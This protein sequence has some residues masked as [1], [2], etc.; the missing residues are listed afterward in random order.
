MY[1]VWVQERCYFGSEFQAGNIFLM[2]VDF[3]QVSHFF[4][5]DSALTKEGT[6]ISLQ[7]S[8]SLANSFHKTVS[9]QDSK[10]KSQQARREFVTL[11]DKK[12][13]AE[14]MQIKYQRRPPPQKRFYGYSPGFQNG[15]R[16]PEPK[17]W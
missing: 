4:H 8:T 6:K 15:K 10:V 16:N 2:G 9:K 11:D 13:C 1:T 5:S 12:V 14:D 3:D 7:N 17:L